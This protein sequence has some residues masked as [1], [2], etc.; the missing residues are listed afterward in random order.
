MKFCKN[1]VHC[2]FVSNCMKEWP[3]PR[4]GTVNLMT[5]DKARSCEWACGAD[6]RGFAEKKNPSQRKIQP[7]VEPLPKPR[8]MQACPHFGLRSWCKKCSHSREHDKEYFCS[9]KSCG[10]VCQTVADPLPACQI[11]G[12][13]FGTSAYCWDCFAA[14]RDGVKPLPPCKLCGAMPQDA[15]ADGCVRCLTAACEIAG[16]LTQGAW[17][18]LMGRE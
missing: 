7:V 8:R 18:K 5:C 9:E 13:P 12:K 3:E 10:V 17:R 1:C 14:V 15:A 2:E 4:I 11:C 6:A 16:A